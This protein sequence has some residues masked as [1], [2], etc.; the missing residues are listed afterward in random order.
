MMHPWFVS[1]V[2]LFW[3]VGVLVPGNACKPTWKDSHQMQHIDAVVEAKSSRHWKAFATLSGTL[4]RVCLT[5]FERPNGPIDGEHF[6]GV[7]RIEKIAL[8]SHSRCQVPLVLG[9]PFLCT[10]NSFRYRV[11]VLQEEENG[12]VVTSYAA[13]RPHS[14]KRTHVSF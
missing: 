8:S 7:L 5:P 1:D 3:S 9:S 13:M 10:Q 14:A 2:Q 6:F 4:V 12:F 11:P